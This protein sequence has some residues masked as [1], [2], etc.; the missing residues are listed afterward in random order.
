MLSFKNR[1]NSCE[2]RTQDRRTFSP[3]VWC[4]STM[5]SNNIHIYYKNLKIFKNSTIYSIILKK[6]HGLFKEN[7]I[8]KSKDFTNNSCS[9]VFILLMNVGAS[10]AVA[11][12]TSKYLLRVFC[13]RNKKFNKDIIKFIRSVHINDKH[14]DIKIIFGFILLSI[15]Q[16]KTC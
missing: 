16:V 8:I 6:C 4:C 3:T 2:N 7:K 1:D 14:K 15:Y 10:W 12:V 13:N 5:A 9:A 11:W